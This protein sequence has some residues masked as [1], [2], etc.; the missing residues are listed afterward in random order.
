MSARREVWVTGIGLVSSLGEGVEAHWQALDADNASAL[1]LT[2]EGYAPYQVHPLVEV[3][4]SQQ[5][6]KRGDQRQMEPWQRIGTYAAGLALNDA[7]IKDDEDLLGRTDMIVSA[8][9]GERD[10][11]ADSA[12][13]TDLLKSNDPG[14]LLN[15]RLSSDLRPTL[16]LAQ[17]PNLLA[18]NISIVH[19]VTGS[20]RT[21]MGE[22]SSGIDAVRTSFAR[23]AAGQSDIALV[24]GSY[25][26]ERDDMLLINVLGD[27]LYPHAWKPVWERENDGGGTLLGSMGAFL[28]LE[29]REVAE[30]RGCKGY[31]ALRGA[32][33][34]RCRRGPGQATA[35]ASG[36]LEKLGGGENLCVISG[37]TGVAPETADERAFL[38]EL[39]GPVRGPA[40]LLG[41]GVEAQ[42]PALVACAAI[43][44]S[45][46]RLFSPID[47]SEAAHEG[48]LGELLVTLWGTW[49]GEG[50]ALLGVID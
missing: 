19:K 17:L 41:H 48:A 45:K 39:A 35:I 47:A 25:S 1:N 14:A 2:G 40:S 50:M 24:G 3:D 7:G 18:G 13:M 42:F 21:F 12:I 22:E 20:S 29:A 43:A 32:E 38:S 5:I 31:A 26:A 33:A 8:G 10:V 23:I 6:P 49:R 9:G 34:G 46:G 36:Q 37:A 28:V 4:F 30:A 16:F 11:E 15:E 27:F 44:L